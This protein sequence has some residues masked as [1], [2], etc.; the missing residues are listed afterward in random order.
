MT[1]AWHIQI[2]L[3][4]ATGVGGFLQFFFKLFK[5]APF[6]HF[7]GLIPRL[8]PPPEGQGDMK[9]KGRF[10]LPNQEE[11]ELVDGEDKKQDLF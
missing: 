7:L 8:T 3:G 2:A 10:G 4:S 9:V 11:L 1:N 6:A 5:K